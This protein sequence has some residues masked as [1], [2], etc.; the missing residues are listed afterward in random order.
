M[1][2]PPTTSKRIKFNEFEIFS[3]HALDAAVGAVVGYNRD[4][5]NIA[6]VPLAFAIAAAIIIIIMQVVL[7]VV[8]AVCI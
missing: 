1:P 4:Y 7:P 3:K 8:G 5:D 2:H 6:Q